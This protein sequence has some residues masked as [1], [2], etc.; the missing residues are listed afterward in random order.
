VH[1][2]SDIAAA[3]S[4]RHLSDRLGIVVIPIRKGGSEMDPHTI[5]TLVVTVLTHLLG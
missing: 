4:A 3:G 1:L 2:N 5:I